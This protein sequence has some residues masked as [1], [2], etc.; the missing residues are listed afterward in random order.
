[1]D[2]KSTIENLKSKIGSL[3]KSDGKKT[4]MAIDIGHFSS[5]LIELSIAEDNVL[6]TKIGS[7]RSF[8]KLKV[9]DP[10]NATKAEWVA[11]AQDL[12]NSLKIKPKSQKNLISS[13]IGSST[14]IKQIVTLELGGSELVQSLEFEAKKHIPLDGTEVIMDYHII[15]DNIKEP[16]KIDVLL[17]ATT[18]N[19]I[20]QHNQLISEIGF[21]NSGVFDATPIALANL[22]TFSKGMPEQGT[23][24]VIN[25]AD[26]VCKMV[27]FIASRRLRPFESS[28]L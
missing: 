3:S 15:G 27:D 13:I 22:H 14:T 19:L 26:P 20:N 17:V 9:F 4:S 16:G 5:K 6:V 7:N 25:R 18:K 2:I 23:D 24:V 28:F 10:D 12:L 1:M 8:N 21:K 11:N